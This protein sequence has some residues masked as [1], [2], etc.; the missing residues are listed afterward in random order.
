MKPN[1]ILL[2][3][4]ALSACGL[5]TVSLRGAE[6]F[7]SR[8]PQFR[9]PGG[10]TMAESQSILIWEKP[11]P[12]TGDTYNYGASPVL[13]DGQVD[14][15][16]DGGEN[17]SLVCLDAVTGKERWT[18]PRTNKIVRFC[19]PYEWSHGGA[20]QVLAGGTGQ[21]GIALGGGKGDLTQTQVRW[22]TTRGLPCVS[23]PLVHRGRLYLVKNGGFLSC[24]DA[25]TGKAHYESERLGVAVEYDATP[26]AVGEHI[27]ICARRGTA[28]VVR[29]GD[30]LEILARNEIGETLSATPAVVD[31]MLYLRGEKHLWAFGK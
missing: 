29:A 9:G 7:P 1:S 4:A 11:L 14:L 31:N 26:V 2:L 8:W 15:N 12:S 22:E 20:K 6:A 25:A 17:S 13:D 10:N 5:M 24:L 23:S 18:A 21:L 19:A 28:F 30:A 27:V 3:A 16:R